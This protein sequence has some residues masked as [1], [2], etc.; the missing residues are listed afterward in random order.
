MKIKSKILDQEFNVEFFKM[1]ENVLGI[2]HESLLNILENELINIDYKVELMSAMS[3]YFSVSCSIE[4]TTNGR[5]VVRIGEVNLDALDK[6]S[7]NYDFICSHP[8]FTAMKYAIDTAVTA[9]LGIS[10]SYAEN[11]IQEEEKNIKPNDDEIVQNEPND[12]EEQISNYSETIPNDEET[13]DFT[14]DNFNPEDY[15]ITEDDNYP[16]V[17]DNYPIVDDNYP[18]VDDNYPIVDDNYPIVDDNYPIVDEET[19]DFNGIYDDN[20]FPIID[21]ENL[22]IIDEENL[23]IID[24]ENLPIIDEENL[25]IIDDEKIPV[26]N[27]DSS[28]KPVKEKST[29]SGRTEEEE[30]RFQELKTMKIPSGKYEGQTIPEVEKINKSWIEFFLSKPNTKYGKMINEYKSL[31]EKGI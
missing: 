1:K 18:I 11:S 4:S 24:E 29:K 21:E 6:K 27:E 12:D 2:T 8:L 3:P 30:K 17:D 14:P 19:Q 26:Q 31:E 10:S 23:P 9:Y 13:Y 28:E 7:Q 16:I 15:P 5:K 22:P 25:P 20:D